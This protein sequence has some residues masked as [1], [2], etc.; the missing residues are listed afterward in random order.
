EDSMKL[1]HNLSF[2]AGLRYEFTTGWNEVAG[3]AANYIA[4]ANGVLL[5]DPG[6]GSSTFTDNKAKRLIGPR[7]ALAWDPKGNG[8]TA[9]RAAFGVHYPLIDTFAFLL[10]PLPPNTPP[11][12]S[13]G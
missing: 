1:A 2:R 13:P 9:V 12:T 3:R 11:F 10:N 5:T 4:D 8:T 7:I 6:L